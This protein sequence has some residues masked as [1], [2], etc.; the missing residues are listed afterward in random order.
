MK[1]GINMSEKTTAKTTPTKTRKPR[2]TTKVAEETGAIKDVQVSAQ[3]STIVNEDG[4]KVIAGST[5]KDN[6]KP[7][8]NL[9][10]KN[11]GGAISSRSADNALAKK[12]APKEEKSLKTKEPE[13]IAVWSNK[14]I[15]WTGVGTL[16]HGYN[17]VTKEAAE[18]WLNRE[19]I[20]KATPEEIAT[21]YGK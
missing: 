16:T 8:S 10:P 18:K 15:R 12:T 3:Q 19:G 13:K 11:D 17:I 21:Y 1:K 2:A 7:K 9:S 5:K 20:R 14:N 6:P 4:Q